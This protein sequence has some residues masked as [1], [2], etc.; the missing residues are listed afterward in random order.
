MN[1]PKP[2]YTDEF[3]TIYHGDCKEILPGIQHPDLLLLDP[4]FNEWDAA[5]QV[6]ATTVLAFTNL[7]SRP[8]IERL[9][10]LPRT[11]LIW[12]FPDGR[13][14]SHRLPLITHESILVYGP[15]ND[16]YVGEAHSQKPH[17]NKQTHSTLS[18]TATP[19]GPYRPRPRRA[20][21]SVITIPQRAGHTPLGR[22]S[23]PAA[24]LTLLIE[25]AATG[26]LLLD[27]YMGSGAS[28]RAAKSLGMR[29]IGIDANER[30]CAAAALAVAQ[31]PL[32]LA[33]DTLPAWEQEQLALRA[34]DAGGGI[35]G[36]ALAL[37]RW[38]YQK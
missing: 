2:Y 7:N 3:A 22:W 13:W 8:H 30:A 19:R 32:P 34:P 5:P 10:G 29:A 25:W 4:P 21:D 18:R 20:L 6:S 37:D 11:E 16:V 35:C 17:Y 36:L 1:N 31:D 12:H 14:V 9:Y 33:L 24:L 38:Y 23:K 15:T 28:L 27:P 26:P